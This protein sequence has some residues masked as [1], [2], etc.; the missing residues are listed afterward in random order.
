MADPRRGCT[1]G[2]M[3]SRRGHAAV[4]PTL[5]ER[6]QLHGAAVDLPGIVSTPMH[7]APYVLGYGG[8]GAVLGLADGAV[9]WISA[10]LTLRLYVRQV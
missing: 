3:T 4:A 10:T 9:L 5:A 6:V 7:A 1:T 2:A 8:L